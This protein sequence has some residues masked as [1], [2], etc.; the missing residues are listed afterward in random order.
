MKG[1]SILQQ[2]RVY[3]G[4]TVGGCSTGQTVLYNCVLVIYFCDSALLPTLM[5]KTIIHQESDSTQ[6]RAT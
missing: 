2:F 1:H 3:K 6:T 5:T 4:L